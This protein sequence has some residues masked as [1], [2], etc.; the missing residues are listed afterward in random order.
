[1]HD[2]SIG[3]AF[4]K[5]NFVVFMHD[6]SA[7]MIAC[8]Y[9]CRVGQQ[10]HTLAIVS[11]VHHTLICGT[12]NAIKGQRERDEEARNYLI[13]HLSDGINLSVQRTPQ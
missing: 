10:Y 5:R 9:V 11:K 4:D 13:T 6:S 1:M 8:V 12:C 2:R 3:R 7:A